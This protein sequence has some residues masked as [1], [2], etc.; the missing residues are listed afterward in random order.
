MYLE[1]GCGKTHI[2][3]L[4]IYE[5]KRLINKPKKDLFIFLA[6]TVALVEQVSTFHFYSFSFFLII[7]LL[8]INILNLC[9]KPTL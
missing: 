8:L 7:Y 6:P 3:V 1:T 4:L 9:S 2:A 5:M